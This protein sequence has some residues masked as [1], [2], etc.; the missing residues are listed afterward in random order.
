M[1]LK[2]KRF[3]LSAF[4]VF[5]SGFSILAQPGGPGD[6]GGDPDVVPISGIEWLIGAG[7]LLGA[8]RLYHLRKPK[9]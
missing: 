6:P 4:I 9:P 1:V 8:K 2:L 3:L 5:L 7:A